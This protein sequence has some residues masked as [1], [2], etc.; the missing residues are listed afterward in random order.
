MP[1]NTFKQQPVHSAPRAEVHLPA[2][3]APAKLLNKK[4]KHP[5]WYINSEYAVVELIFRNAVYELFVC[6]RQRF[7]RAQWMQLHT[8][9]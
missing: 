8:S 1:Y 7:A 4:V 5:K 3:S 2:L 9:S 6:V